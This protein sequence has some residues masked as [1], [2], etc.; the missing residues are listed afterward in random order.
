MGASKKYFT[1]LRDYFEQKYSFVEIEITW[2]T[3]KSKENE[4][5]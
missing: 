1:E 4:D 3:L 5:N 2:E